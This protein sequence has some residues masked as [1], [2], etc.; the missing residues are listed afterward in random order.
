MKLLLERSSSATVA[1]VG[2]RTTLRPAIASAYLIR[3]EDRNLIAKV[4]PGQAK[5]AE[6][7]VEKESKKDFDFF[8]SH[9]N[10]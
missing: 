10:R 9:M 5:Q 6:V 7:T 4:N 2:H 3:P 8:C 1:F